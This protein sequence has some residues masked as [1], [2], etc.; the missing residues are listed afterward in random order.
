MSRQL[1]AIC[2]SQPSI[3]HR[4]LCRPLEQFNLGYRPTA[5]VQSFVALRRFLVLFSRREQLCQHARDRQQ[6]WEI[7]GVDCQQLVAVFNG[8]RKII[9]LLVGRHHPLY[10][11]LFGVIVGLRKVADKFLTS[12]HD[13]VQ[14]PQTGVTVKLFSM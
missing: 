6:R 14:I 9:L 8:F 12:F 4:D 10:N 11:E 5:V 2:S 1:P 13:L 7:R 3:A